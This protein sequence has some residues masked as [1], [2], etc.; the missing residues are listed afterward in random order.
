MHTHP[1]THAH[2]HARH[3]Y[4]DRT[5]AAT[6]TLV[7]AAEIVDRLDEMSNRIQRAEA[8]ARALQQLIATGVQ[9]HLEQ[10]K[11]GEG[12]VEEGG[13]QGGGVQ[14]GGQGVQEGV[15][16]GGE[17][18]CKGIGEGDAAKGSG[19]RSTPPKTDTEPVVS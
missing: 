1:P 18:E 14:E 6:K 7:P 16:G 10:C 8:Q 9:S 2:T 3:R 13:V 19:G 11:G 12:G 5:H 15:E 4:V 17:K